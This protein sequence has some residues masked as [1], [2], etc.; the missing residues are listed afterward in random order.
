MR[1]A[2]RG[3]LT[4]PRRRACAALGGRAL[5]AARS[6]VQHFNS[7]ELLDEKAALVTRF[8][9]KAMEV[10]TLASTMRIRPGGEGRAQGSKLIL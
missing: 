5:V 10:R 2:G 3:R 9:N 6:F 1:G 4:R 8:L 7:I